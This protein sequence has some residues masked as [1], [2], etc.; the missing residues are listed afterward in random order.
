MGTGPPHFKGRGYCS[1][2]RQVQS[3][4]TLSWPTHFPHPFSPA[5][6]SVQLPDTSRGCG[7][8]GHSWWTDPELWLTNSPLVESQWVDNSFEF[9]IRIPQQQHDFSTFSWLH[10]EKRTF[11]VLT[12]WAV[13]HCWVV[14][15]VARAKRCK[16]S[17]CEPNINLQNLSILC[18]QC[19]FMTHCTWYVPVGLLL[20]LPLLKGL[21]KKH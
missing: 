4:Y 17:N 2:E 7:M 9:I 16:S 19:D 8:F 12:A 11:H 13:G 15:A 6:A 21:L 20:Y 3:F 1:R 14:S 5:A 18:F 10:Y